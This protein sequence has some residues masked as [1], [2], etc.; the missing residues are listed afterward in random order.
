MFFTSDD[1]TQGQKE[2]LEGDETTG[3]C[4]PPFKPCS[5]E[6]ESIY[7]ELVMKIYYSSW[8]SDLDECQKELS[9]SKFICVTGY[10]N[11][12]NKDGPAWCLPSFV[13]KSDDCEDDI[14]NTL[15]EKLGNSDEFTDAPLLPYYPCY[16]SDELIPDNQNWKVVPMKGEDHGFEPA[17]DG[18]VWNM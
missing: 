15:D 9:A 6:D 14:W 8:S 17:D 4:L 12:L 1:L 3:Y 7:E 10:E 2:C 18:S 16:D 5:C 11:C 13:K